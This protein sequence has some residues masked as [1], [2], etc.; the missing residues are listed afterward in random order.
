MT[1]QPEARGAFIYFGTLYFSLRDM[2]LSGIDELSLRIAQLWRRGPP[3]TTP[4]SIEL[5][6]DHDATVDP[7]DEREQTRRLAIALAKALRSLP[8]ET[9]RAYA[10]RSS[11][12]RDVGGPDRRDVFFRVFVEVLDHLSI[13]DYEAMPVMFPWMFEP[14]PGDRDTP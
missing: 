10:E 5:P 14:D 12:N 6:P 8:P 3:W 4:S 2:A 11:S 13:Q 1:T 7:A 9:A